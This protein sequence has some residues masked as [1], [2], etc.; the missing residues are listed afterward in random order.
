MEVSAAEIEIIEYTYV[1]QNYSD[2]E[3]YY[4]DKSYFDSEM[5]SDLKTT[6][7]EL[8]N[9]PDQIKKLEMHNIPLNLKLLQIGSKYL[10]ELILVN[11]NLTSLDCI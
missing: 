4:L 6:E 1:N 7:K 10:I 3:Y 8:E 11:C 9:I 5:M 2:D